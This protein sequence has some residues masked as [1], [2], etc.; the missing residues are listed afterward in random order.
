MSKVILTDIKSKISSDLLA[1]SKASDFVNKLT[2]ASSFFQ[3]SEW[4]KM[5][6]TDL[7]SAHSLADQFLSV[8]MG[9]NPYAIYDNG[10]ALSD[11]SGLIAKLTS[12]Q[13]ANLKNIDSGKLD[14][15]FQSG[16]VFMQYIGS[17]VVYS[18]TTVQTGSFQGAQTQIVQNS[19]MS[20]SYV[21]DI[22][23]WMVNGKDNF[24][25]YTSGWVTILTYTFDL[26]SKVMTVAVVD[27]IEI[28]SFM[29]NSKISTYNLLAATYTINVVWGVLNGTVVSN[30]VTYTFTPNSDGSTSTLIIVVPQNLTVQGGTTTYISLEPI[31]YSDSN[32]IV[33]SSPI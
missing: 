14:G 29:G 25:D 15:L 13:M 1:I 17:T 5:K 21:Y 11:S 9:S 24:G 12:K 7:N 8:T 26:T 30:G 31:L 19:A 10:C 3:S 4:Q 2:T 16:D 20:T 33:K 18:S 22:Q 28:F 32:T 23:V 27:Y 6:S